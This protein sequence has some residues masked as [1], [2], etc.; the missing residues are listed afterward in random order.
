MKK[1][2]LRTYGR[3]CNAPAHR[4]LNR[5]DSSYQQTFCSILQRRAA[6]LSNFGPRRSAVHSFIEGHVTKMEQGGKDLR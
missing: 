6:F 5:S 1:S 3:T 4:A 2:N